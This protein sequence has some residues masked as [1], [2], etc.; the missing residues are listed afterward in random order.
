MYV[1]SSL[2]MTFVN[3]VTGLVI[4]RFLSP[5]EMGLWNSAKL[6]VTYSFFALAGVLNGFG[7]ELPFSL[8]KEDHEGASKLASTA[9]FCV[10]V[11]SILCFLGGCVVAAMFWEAGPDRLLAVVGVSAVIVLNFQRC[12]YLATFRSSRAFSRLAI[13]QYMEAGLQLVS[14]PLVVWFG[15][16]GMIGRVILVAFLVLLVLRHW[17]PMRV[18]SRFDRASFVRLLKTGFPIFALDYVRSICSTVDRLVL[19]A[20][21]GVTAVGLYTLA[22]VAAEVMGALPQSFGQ[23]LSPRMTFDYGKTGDP[24]VLW[25]RIIRGSLLAAAACAGA[26]LAGSWLLRPT[27]EWLAPQYI[28]GIVAAK[29]MLWCGVPQALAL[30]ASAL[31]AMKRWRLMTLYQLSGSALMALTP[32]LFIG[33]ID[34]MLLAV[35]W[36]VFVGSMLRAVLALV[37]A[38]RGT[39]AT[40]IAATAQ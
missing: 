26:A 2:L 33:R 15:Y 10:D 34:N 4:I 20:L 28:D 35:A 9:A 30:P 14:V 31:W 3:L 27:V 32:M 24:L 23:Y 29:V 7:R 25:N 1:S 13:N 37:V 36:G 18:P 12:Y 19:L 6:G 16:E 11:A 40:P 39:H 38:Y 17:R 8:G 21:G 22:V 5:T